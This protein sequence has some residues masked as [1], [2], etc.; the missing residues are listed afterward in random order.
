MARKPRYPLNAFR[1]PGDYRPEDWALR[2]RI[3]SPGRTRGV[4]AR[5]AV[6]GLM[7]FLPVVALLLVVWQ[8]GMMHTGRSEARLWDACRTAYAS[9]SPKA[10]ALLNEFL[11]VHPDS[12]HAA[13]GRR[14][15]ETLAALGRHMPIAASV[16]T[17][18]SASAVANSVFPGARAPRAAPR[19]PEAW[20]APC[21]G[22]VT[23]AYG[24]DSH[25]VTARVRFHEGVDFQAANAVVTASRSGVVRH[26]GSNEAYPEYGRFVVMDH[27]GH[28]FS[29][30]ANASHLLVEVGDR[31][32][33][34]DDIAVGGQ[35]AGS[36]GRR[37]HFEILYGAEGGWREAQR[38]DP[39]PFLG[40]E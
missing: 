39:A 28:Q 10:V 15:L 34:G 8:V 36:G 1:S 32:S 20:L 3:G 21:D 7:R 27:G 11:A 19:L 16:R 29:L 14:R 24:V 5:D 25:P 18:A 26:A 33:Q 37:C 40:I 6:R 35:I 22:E 4:P 9:G 30:Y 13:D 2:E 38:L 23:A 17:T 31:M 12:D